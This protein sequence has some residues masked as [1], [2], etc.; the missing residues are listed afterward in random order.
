MSY[1]A[2]I[3]AN[4]DELRT[5][6]AGLRSSLAST[7]WALRALGVP[8]DQRRALIELRRALM[9]LNTLQ[10]I[11]QFSGGM[12]AISL[13]ARATGFG[14]AI[15]GIKIVRKLAKLGGD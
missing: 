12:S 4:S 3:S 1:H 5:D 8:A 6:L 7:N 2:S 13:V 11:S 10:M 14:G 9:V 15:G